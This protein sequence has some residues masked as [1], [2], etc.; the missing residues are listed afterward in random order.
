MNSDMVINY[1]PLF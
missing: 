1:V